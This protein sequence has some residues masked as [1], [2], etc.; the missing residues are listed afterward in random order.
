MLRT[1]YSAVSQL[2]TILTSS[3]PSLS[4]FFDFPL[5]RELEVKNIKEA[6]T[7]FIPTQKVVYNVILRFFAILRNTSIA[8]V[9]I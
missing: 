5:F 9:E 3:L 6:M 7:G 4:I 1:D 8:Q 2:E